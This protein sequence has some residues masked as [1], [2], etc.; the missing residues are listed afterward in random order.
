MLGGRM[1]DPATMDEV[2]TGTRKRA[3]F[4]WQADGGSGA[5]GTPAVASDVD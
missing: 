4:W 2:V 5:G 3:P 1:Y